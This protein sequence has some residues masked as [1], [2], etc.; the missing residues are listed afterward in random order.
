M[1]G[2]ITI[3]RLSNWLWKAKSVFTLSDVIFPMRLEGKLEIDR[4]PAIDSHASALTQKL[5]NFEFRLSARIVVS[6][7]DSMGLPVGLTRGIDR[8]AHRWGVVEHWLRVPVMAGNDCSVHCHVNLSLSFYGAVYR[9]V[10]LGIHCVTCTAAVSC[11][12]AAVSLLVSCLIFPCCTPKASWIC[13]IFY[14]VSYA[15]EK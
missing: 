10:L 13:W 2:S 11:S 4:G 7:I 3:F 14:H 1:I 5:T 9:P 12:S 6:R 15:E 8:D